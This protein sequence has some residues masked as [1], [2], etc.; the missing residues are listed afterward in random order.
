MTDGSTLPLFPAD[1]R[2]S[3]SVR[4][5]S[6]EAQAMTAGSG[7]RLYESY[8]SYPRH[9]AF[10]KTYLAYFLSMPVWSSNFCYL[11][12]SLQDMKFSRSIIRLRASVPRTDGTE[13]SLL[14]TPV[15]PSGGGE[16]SGDRAG[17]G[18]LDYM[19]RTGLLA[20]PTAKANQL[21]P[22]MQR[23]PSCQAMWPTPTVQDSANNGGP[24]QLNRNTPPLNAVAG[25]SL[26]PTW[27]E[28]FMGFPEGWTDLEHSGTP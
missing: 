14:P 1:S 27:V 18:T 13:C 19:A 22:A 20:T 26:N 5:G 24:S 23:W 16:R 10:W 6:A 15:T 21:A 25:G 2:A 9:G 4:P 11:N 12:W 7:R 3:R 28:W 17:T 8:A